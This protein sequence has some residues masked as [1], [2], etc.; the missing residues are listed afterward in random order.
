VTVLTLARNLSRY[1]KTVLSTLPFAGV[2]GAEVV[3]ALDNG[4][5]DGTF[6]RADL[7]AV[8]VAAVAPVLV[9]LKRNT[10]TDPAVAATESVTLVT[11]ED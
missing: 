4:S 10:T 1:A 5:A 8:I 7:I 2:V 11:P 6:D 9:Y 3:Q